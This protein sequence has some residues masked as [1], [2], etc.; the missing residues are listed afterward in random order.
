[1]GQKYFRCWKP[2]GLSQIFYS[3]N[4]MQKWPPQYVSNYLKM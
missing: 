4:V 2:R 1:M 3:A